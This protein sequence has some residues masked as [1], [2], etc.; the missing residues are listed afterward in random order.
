MTLPPPKLAVPLSLKMPPP[1]TVAVLPLMLLVSF[2]T[3]KAKV[4]MLLL[5]L[6]VTAELPLRFI[7]NR[8]P[9]VSSCCPS[10]FLAVAGQRSRRRLGIQVALAQA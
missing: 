8:C 3:T 6:S 4:L 7:R 5:P 10:Y 2:K 9:V 1:L